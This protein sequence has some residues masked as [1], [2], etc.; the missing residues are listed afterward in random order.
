M[1]HGPIRLWFCFAVAV[2]AAAVADPCV[3]ALS[4]AGVFGSGQF[5][6]RSSLDV[7]PALIVGMLLLATYF[8]LR[9]R[10]E[11]LRSSVD[12]V[13]EGVV[14]LLPATFVVQLGVLAA[15]ETLEQIVVYGHA[16]GGTIWLGGPAIFSLL[17]HAFACIGF[18]CALSALLRIG[19]RTTVRAIRLVRAL[20]VRAL[21]G[22]A[23]LATR[24]WAA[25]R[26]L[27]LSPVLSP[28]GNRAPPV[29]IV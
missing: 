27:R 21:H 13:R 8:A 17:V 4:N 19:A 9:V 5:T 28:M 6:D 14:T 7:V 29:A 2:L 16:L 26:I 24:A 15:M 20:L 10:R 18:A 23:P 11:L 3:E 25:V 1:K 12:A 22:P